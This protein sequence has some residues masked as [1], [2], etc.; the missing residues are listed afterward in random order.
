MDNNQ[1]S[2]NLEEY[3][4]RSQR[5]LSPSFHTRKVLV[6]GTG[7][8]S[9]LAEKLGRMGPARL[10]FV[11]C[12]TVDVANLTR[13]AFG[14][15][16]LGRPKAA[17]LADRI[18]DANPFVEVCSMVADICEMDEQELLNLIQSVD[19]IIAG[20]DHFPAQ[21][22]LNRL[23]CRVSVPAVFVGIHE[24]AFGGRIIWTLPGVTPCYHCVAQERYLHFEEAGEVT[25]DLAG[26]HGLLVDM[27]CIDMVALKV[28][29][30]ILERGQDSAMGHF[31]HHMGRR[32]EIIVRTTPEY[33]YGALLWEAILSDLPTTPK[34]YA[35]ELREQVLFAMDTVWLKT[36]YLPGCP[37]CQW[38]F[39]TETGP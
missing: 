12:D 6:V 7:G 11:D 3:Y 16:D 34:P 20:T 33:E 15:R 10:V 23:S 13:T 30:A 35:Q 39:A 37:D 24:A 19:L 32:N 5:L 26:A 14:V 21:A 28:A 22:L 29:V 38:S 2:L 18:R 36:E 4:R 1:L 9:Y 31:F 27:Q 25:T 17:A 8:G